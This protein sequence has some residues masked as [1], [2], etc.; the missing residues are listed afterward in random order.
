MIIQKYPISTRAVVSELIKRKTEQL[1]NLD[2]AKWA[3]W[4]DTDGTFAIRT[5]GGTPT[6]RLA[7]KDM[8]PVKL[9]SETFEHTYAFNQFKTVSPQGKTYDAKVY[10]CEVNS[11]G[12]CKWLAEN[13]F[14]YLIGEEK[15]NNAAKVIGYTP[16]SKPFDEWTKEEAL[17]YFATAIDGDG[18]VQLKNGTSVCVSLYSSSAEYLG[19]VK[20]LMESKFNVRFNMQQ[21]ATY[22]TKAGTRH[23][24]NIY[25]G[26]NKDNFD[27]YKLLVSNNV[28]TLERKREKILYFLKRKKEI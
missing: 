19:Q 7:I 14:P 12:K 13:M 10:V 11:F 15:K 8:E 1:T 4:F 26:A 25:L 17:A 28:M 22:K 2:W 23:R 9:F 27:L 20:E 21:S 24:F 5:R 18:G 3:G 16:K 6:V